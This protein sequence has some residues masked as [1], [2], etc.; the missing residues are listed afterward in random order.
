[1]FFIMNNELGITNFSKIKVASL[2]RSP[3]SNSW[4]YII[5]EILNC[6]DNRLLCSAFEL[7]KLCI[8]TIE[9]SSNTIAILV[10]E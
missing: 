2:I 9:I 10:R 3:I 4:K 8:R 7:K 6:D 1:M 5:L